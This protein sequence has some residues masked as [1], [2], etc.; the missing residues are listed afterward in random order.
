MKKVFITLCLAVIGINAIAQI[1]TPQPSP[2]ASFKQALGLGE[3]SVNYSRPAMKGRVVF[4]DLVP[5]DKIWRTGANN[6]TKINFSDDVII[7]GNKLPAGE[8]ALYA[9]PSK[10]EWTIIFHKNLKLWGL[11]EPGDYK[12]ENDALRIKVKPSML[13]SNVESFTISTSDITA[14]SCKV[15]IEWE[16]TKVSFNVVT[17]ID[18]KIM[19][20]IEK[21]FN[22]KVDA[23]S[24]YSAASYYYENN[25]DM[26]K[27]LE[28]VNQ[29]ISLRADAFWMVHLK[30]KILKSMN[31]TTEAIEAANLSKEI[32]SK[33]GNADYVAMNDKLIAE[34][35]PA[36]APSKSKKK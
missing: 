28:W 6:S 27:A 26:A 23:N 11:G 24:Y 5:F 20:S 34:M 30:A 3:V 25:K 1:K 19:A 29:A 33:A 2:A 10:T 8:Y 35:S 14:N 17:E 32:A 21:T 15:N 31:K 16:R 36:T 4:G 12:E 13:P 18:A 9:I 22:P 7:E